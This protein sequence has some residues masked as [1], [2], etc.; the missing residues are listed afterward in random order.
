MSGH[1][2]VR[3]RVL[4]AQELELPGSQSSVRELLNV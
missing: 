2:L 1:Q 3:T 4:D